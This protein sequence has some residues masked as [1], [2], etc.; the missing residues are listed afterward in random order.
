MPR[1]TQRPALL[2]SFEMFNSSALS[3]VLYL[4]NNS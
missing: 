3:G 4:D 1:K 2:T